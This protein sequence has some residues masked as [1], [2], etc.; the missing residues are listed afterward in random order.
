MD[1][2]GDMRCLNVEKGRWH[3]FECLAPGSV[4]F[5]SKDGAYA[6]LSENEIMTLCRKM[7]DGKR[8]IR[9]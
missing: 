6:P 2:D 9:R 3:L 4:L 7:N 8:I 5:E 1:A